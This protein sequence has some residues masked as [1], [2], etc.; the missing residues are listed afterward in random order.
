M[1]GIPGEAWAV[2]GRTQ[3]VEG[4]IYAPPKFQRVDDGLVGIDGTAG[5]LHGAIEILR[6]AFSVDGKAYIDAKI[7]GGL[8]DLRCY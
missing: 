7:L 5:L 3:G 8:Q 6:F 4:K 1:Q 2:I